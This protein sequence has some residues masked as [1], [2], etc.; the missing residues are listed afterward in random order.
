MGIVQFSHWNH[1]EILGVS[2][3]S[4]W[5]TDIFTAG[6]ADMDSLQERIDR[7]ERDS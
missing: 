4:W 3:I 7:P 5:S 1:R 2:V 6:G